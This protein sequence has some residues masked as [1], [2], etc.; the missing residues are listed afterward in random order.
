MLSVVEGAEALLPVSLDEAE[1]EA[2]D[3]L[4]EAAEPP[5]RK[6]AACCLFPARLAAPTLLTGHPE[7]SHAICEQ[8]PRNGGDESRH[9]YQRKPGSRQS[10]ARIL[11]QAPAL[12]DDGWRWSSGQRPSAVVHG[13][14]V[15]QP[16]KRVGWSS[17]M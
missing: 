1:E 3:A 15:Q 5:D 13:S 7:A 4:E 2:D 12:K 11:L 8:Q 6:G 16:T 10:C 9:V 17:Q 14:M